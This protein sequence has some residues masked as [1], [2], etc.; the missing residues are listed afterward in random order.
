MPKNTQ[1]NEEPRE[2]QRA[3][4][5]NLFLF[6]VLPGVLALACLAAYAIVFRG[7]PA[8][9]P[10]SWGQFGDF[11]GGMIN[12]V[13]GMITIILLV[14]T[15]RAQQEELRSQLAQAQESGDA[16]KKQ[17]EATALQSF[18][19]TLF[20]WFGNYKQIVHGLHTQEYDDYGELKPPRVGLDAIRKWAFKIRFSWEKENAFERRLQEMARKRADPA[21]LIQS[22]IEEAAS[23]LM[24]KWED[25]MAD[26]SHEI[27]PAMRTLFGI[28]KWISSHPDE[29]LS[30][31]KKRLY[32]GIIRAQLTDNELQLLFFNGLTKRGEAFS[33]LANKFALF[34]NLD[35]PNDFRM[36]ILLRSSRNLYEPSAFGTNPPN[37]FMNPPASK[38]TP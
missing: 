15:F 7:N 21:T 8:G 34:D 9:E 11:F 12:P 14:K 17:A 32:S 38:S 26:G 3:A 23:I 1:H 2:P 25:L 36:H 10:E 28:F 29:F 33:S 13:V 27:K 22:E 5:S 20:T 37:F 6:W 35:N 19:Q 30:I 16:L 4:E 18:E 31:E 24:Q